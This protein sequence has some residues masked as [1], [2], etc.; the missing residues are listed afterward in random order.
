MLYRFPYNYLSPLEIPDENLLGV[1]EAGQEKPSEPPSDILARALDN[2]IGSPRLSELAK[3]SRNALILCDDNTRYT[4][5]HIVL[6]PVIEELHRGGISD[7]RIRILI[8][9][10][11]HRD[12]TPEELTARLGKTIAGSYLIE[13]HAYDD[14]RELVPT[15]IVRDGVEFLVNR[16]LSESDLVIGLGNIIPHCIKGFSGGCN[17]VL[18]GVSGN[19]AIGAMHW[20]NLDCFGE[21]ILGVRDNIVRSLIDDVAVKAGLNFIVNTI[22]NNSMD[23]I[24]TVAGHPV[25]A[26]RQGTIIASRV[27]T[28]E[29]PSRADIVIFDAFNNDLDFWQTTKGLLPAYICMKKDAVLIDVADCPEG[30]CHNIPE[31]LQYGFK[32]LDTIMRLH[33][34]GVL[35]PVITHFLISV[36]RVVT[37]RG[38]CIMVS[39]SITEQD[40]EQTGLI[41]AESPHKA[42]NK[43]FSM[44]GRDASVIVLR[45]AGNIGPKILKKDL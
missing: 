11:T 21:E 12:M 33:R 29:I 9:K 26:H 44:K 31:I 16:R 2:P 43:A 28:V 30:I 39:R 1:F 20:K 17:I 40:A 35:H 27:F 4:P 15:G 38:R 37:E 25:E 23:I 6:P 32:D 7:D 5:A 13:Q 34:D 18:P 36:Y 10:G 45:H 19:D 14:K 22:V 24:D 8:A 41:F 42:L 3:L